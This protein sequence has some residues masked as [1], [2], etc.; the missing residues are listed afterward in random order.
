MAAPSET[1]IR[2]DKEK[3]YDRQLR[4]WGDHG[5]AALESAKI[6]LINATATGTEILKNLVLPGIGSFTI[7]DG[8]RVSGQDI[9]NNFFL[10]KDN[11]GKSR[12]KVATELLCELNAD[13]SGDCVEET[14]EQL[15]E[16][17]PQVFEVFDVV[18]VTELPERTLLDLAT[19]LWG[20]DVPLL[21]CRSYGFI[22]YMRM[23]IKEHTVIE[24]HPDNAHEDLRL[25]RQFPG[26][27]KYIDGMNLLSMTKQEHSHTPYLV[28]IAKYLHQWKEEHEGNPPKNYK[29]KNAFKDM[30]REGVRKNEEGVEELEENFDEAVKNVNNAL[31]PTVIPDDVKNIFND[32]CCVNLTS[33][34]SSF[35]IV[36]HAIKQFTENEGKGALPLRGSIPDMTADSKRYIQLQNVYREQASQDYQAITG[37]V[38]HILNTL[39]LPLDYVADS[40]IKLF[41]KNAHF[42]RVVR[43]RPLA[44]EYNPEKAKTADIATNLENPDNEIVF[45]ILL[46]AVDR[47]YSQY[48]RYPGFYDDQVEADIPKLKNCLNNILQEWGL[49]PSL[50]KDDYIHEMCRYGASE[51]HTVAAFMGGAAAQEV[52][53]IVT[54]QFLPFNNT[55]IY[56]GM[57]STSATYSL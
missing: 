51:L 13:V 19:F 40:D 43:C 26:L 48:S 27:V 24:S 44:Q 16:S 47:F 46:R 35:W 21:I 20:A 45:Y 25:D 33:D 50:I 28:I 49:S 52:V 41:C 36:S 15:L 17:N 4:L 57:T 22:G 18:I 39:G 5:Q 6:C 10:D 1:G 11:L 53:K 55:F 12:A 38:H 7:I 37:R 29:E 23:A 31:V 8:N 54:K 2:M 30:I 56:N 14:V 42:V 3:K 34:S 9:G 32:D